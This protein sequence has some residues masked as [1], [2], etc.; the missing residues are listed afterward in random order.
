V[1]V[2]LSASNQLGS[3]AT[4]ITIWN[5]HA[6]TF[7]KGQLLEAAESDEDDKWYVAEPTFVRRRAILCEDLAAAEDVLGVP[8]SA[9]A[10]LLRV[11][12]S[13]QLQKD[14]DTD[15]VLRTVTVTNF[16]EHISVGAGTYVKIEFQEGVWEAYAADCGAFDSSSSAW[17]CED[18]SL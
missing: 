13:G 7:R 3:E 10:I 14:R 8:G 18:E 5:R 16:Y 6:A 2:G 9:M 1:K 15:E 12:D 4:K 11:N 17:D